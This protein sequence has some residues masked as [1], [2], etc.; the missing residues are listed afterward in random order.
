M[1][2]LGWTSQ[3]VDKS[4]VARNPQKGA[5][6]IRA[7]LFSLSRMASSVVLGRDAASPKRK[8]L[9]INSRP[10]IAPDDPMIPRTRSLGSGKLL[11]S[12]EGT[13]RRVKVFHPGVLRVKNL[14]WSQ[15]VLRT[16]LLRSLPTRSCGSSCGSSYLTRF[17]L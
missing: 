8:P 12:G 14:V 11:P 5:I 7:D 13:F 1:Q 3:I 4:V 9:K 16:Q 2:G 10:A 6:A 17:C 15:T